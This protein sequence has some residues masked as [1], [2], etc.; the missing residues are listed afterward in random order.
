MTLI[1]NKWLILG[2]LSI[3][4][5]SCISPQGGVQSNL[6]IKEDKTYFPVYQKHTQKFEVIKNFKTHH[7]IQVTLLHPEF[8][9]QFSDRYK[10]LYNDNKP[11]FEDDFSKKYGFFISAYSHNREISDLA[12]NNYWNIALKDKNKLITPFL[13]KELTTKE[14]WKPFFTELTP[15]SREYLVIFD[16]PMTYRQSDLMVNPSKQ[17][18]ISSSHGKIT[19]KYP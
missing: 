2:L 14:K 4:S 16:L 12:D 3:L 6:T 7:I 1:K 10:R 11:I 18:F 13:V 5:L 17:L 15:W 19:A 9:K 8:L